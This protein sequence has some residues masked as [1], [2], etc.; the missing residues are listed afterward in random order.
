MQDKTYKSAIVLI[1]PKESW[2]AIQGIRREY[3][4]KIKRWM[5]HITLV[6]PFWPKEEFSQAKALLEP[7]LSSFP[8]FTITLREIYY[9]SHGLQ[10]YTLWLGPE[11]KGK[12]IEL[13][14]TLS[15]ILPNSQKKEEEAERFNP[16]LT[17]GQIHGK[18]RLPKVCSMIREYWQSVSFCVD[19]IS[20]IWREDP[21]KDAFQVGEEIFL[22]KACAKSPL[23]IL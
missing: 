2:D 23:E 17:I 4:S 8:S 3:D 9:F 5:P 14:H 18:E 7:A 21:P 13:Y 6:Y 19:R 22:G 15:G 10:N 20:L 16:H 12:I 11:P 1:P